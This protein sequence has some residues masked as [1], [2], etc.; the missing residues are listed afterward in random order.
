MI[1]INPVAQ[2]MKM[3]K[4]EGKSSYKATTTASNAFANTLNAVISRDMANTVAAS[5]HLAETENRKRK[6]IIEDGSKMVEEDEDNES[7]YKTVRKIETRL[8]KLARLERKM[9]AGF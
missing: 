1:E 9:M 2:F 7:I 6:E 4:I 8:V 3:E 5:Q